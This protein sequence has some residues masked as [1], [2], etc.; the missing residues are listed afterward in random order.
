MEVRGFA[1][2]GGLLECKR[3]AGSAVDGGM[4]LWLKLG[5]GLAGA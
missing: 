3:S 4:E 1:G 5:L 2:Y